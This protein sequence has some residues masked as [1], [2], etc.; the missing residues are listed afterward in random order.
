MRWMPLVVVLGACGDPKVS[1]DARDIDSTVP[2]DMGIDA[3][4]NNPPTLLDTGLCVD[5][6]C[7]QI[8]AGVKAYTPQFELYS[9][10]ASKRR[11]IFLPPGT[12]I[13]TTDMDFWKFPVGTKV[14]KEFTSGT[15]RVETRLVMRISDT[16]PL[17]D[18]FYVSY[19]WNQ[20]QDA[21]TAE[22]FGLADANGTQHDVPSRALCKQCHDNLQPSRVL[23]FSAIQLDWDNPNADELDLKS[24]VDSNLLT[25]PPTGTIPY[26][27]VPGVTRERTALGYMHANCGHCHNPTSKIYMDN[28]VL[29]QLRLTVGTLGSVGATLP[30]TTAVGIDG[31]TSGIN[32]VKKLVTA[33]MPNL[34]QIVLRFES[35][36]VAL[37]MPIVGTEMIDT[38]AQAALRDWI[39]NLP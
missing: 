2:I 29:M 33:G 37:K 21:A 25:A 34:S 12:R 9:D 26:F 39:T 13:D 3:D 31:T 36:N 5:A 10:G 11:W 24:L 20:T 30:Y 22:P 27:P 1:P 16:D 32:G 8:A 35:T 28:G 17:K 15:T 38:T 7:T 4:P 18:W 14:W 6:A 19:I 23:G